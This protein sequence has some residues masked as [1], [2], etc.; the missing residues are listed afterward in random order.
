MT[1][2]IAFLEGWSW[3]KFNNLG[4]A[5]SANLRFCTS[6]EKGLKLNVSKFWGPNPTFVEVT[7]EKLVGGPFCP[8]PILNRVKGQ[9][10]RFFMCYFCLTPLRLECSR[11]R[12]TASFLTSNR[13][14]KHKNLHPRSFTNGVKAW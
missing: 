14:K 13:L 8:P 1:R 7:E 6:V 12:N 11:S 5:L 3:F 10:F 2:K 9:N 4:L